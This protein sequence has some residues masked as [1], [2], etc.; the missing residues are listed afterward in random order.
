MGRRS[1]QERSPARHYGGF[2]PV[3]VREQAAL[4]LRTLLHRYDLAEFQAQTHAAD[5]IDVL[6]GLAR[7]PTV[8]VDYRII[9][10]RT[11]GIDRA[12][13]KP[14]TKATV[15]MV[16]T[17]AVGPD[18]RSIGET[19][20]AARLNADAFTRLDDLVRRGVPS[21]MWPDDIRLLAGDVAAS[22]AETKVVDQD[23]AAA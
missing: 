2:D 7:D 14:A 18:G 21:E 12:S 5:M 8:P 1:S 19:I 15:T 13:G 23:V 16:N 11:R 20:E 9:A 17:Q 3:V 4:Q 22:Y 10:K 6:A